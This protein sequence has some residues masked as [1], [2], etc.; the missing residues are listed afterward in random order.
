MCAYSMLIYAFQGK[1]QNK[2]IIE[3]NSYKFNLQIKIY[4]FS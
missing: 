4:V 2:L 1:S 3:L